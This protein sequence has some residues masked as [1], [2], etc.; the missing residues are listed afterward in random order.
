MINLL[1]GARSHCRVL[2]CAAT[3]TLLQQRCKIIF[4]LLNDR[5]FLDNLRCKS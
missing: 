1:D 2:Q 3:H 4:Q 5:L